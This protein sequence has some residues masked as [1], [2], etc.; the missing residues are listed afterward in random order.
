MKKVLSTRRLRLWFNRL[1]YLLISR[2]WTVSIPLERLGSAY[3]GWWVPKSLAGGSVCYLVG[4]GEDATLDI[5]LSRMGCEVHSFDPT[6][7]AAEY[8]AELPTE[9]RGQ[10]RFHPWAIW[11]DD[12][13]VQFFEPRDRKHVSHSIVDLQQTGAAIRVPCRTLES[14]ADDFGHDRIALLKLDVE[15]AQDEILQHLLRTGRPRVDT[16]CVEFDQPSTLRKMIRTT[17]QLV[18]SDFAIGHVEAFNVTFVS[19]ATR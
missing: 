8:I 4:V 14:T 16:I 7:R 9:E 2:L 1:V 18:R 12:G 19:E 3:G 17:R 13:T 5:A 11:I 15:G 10:L 6:P